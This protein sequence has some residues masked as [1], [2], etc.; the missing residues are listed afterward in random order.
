MKKFWTIFAFWNLSLFA[1]SSSEVTGY[2]A[3]C[4]KAAVDDVVFETFKSNPT[5]QQILEH[6]SMKT[7]REYLD[8]ILRMEPTAAQLFDKFREND[9]LGRPDIYYYDPHGWFSPTT[10]RYVKVACDLKKLLGDLRQIHIVEIGGGYGGQCK[11]L[12]DFTGFASYTLIDIPEALA[13]TKKYL[14]LLGIQNVTYIENKNL[15]EVGHY[16]LVISNFAF[17]EIDRHEQQN[18][19]QKV[20]YPSQHGYM[21]MNFQTEYLGSIPKDEIVRLLI[22]MQ[23]KPRVQKEY[24]NTHPNNII[25]SW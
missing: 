1:I 2:P 22:G 4:A 15:H 20:I 21:T 23:K 16:D 19:L 11:I 3:F 5:F 10:L 24:P 13:L 12:S 17:S 6:V 9:T 7:G 14:D 25:L 18:Y 8:V